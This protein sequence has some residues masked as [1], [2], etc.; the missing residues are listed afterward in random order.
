MTN[1]L[2][3]AEYLT[4]ILE[5]KFKLFGVSIGL[6]P[7]IGLLFG[8]GDIFTLLVGLYYIWVAKIHKIPDAAIARMIGNI[9][10]DFFIGLIPF[11]GDLF[12]FS[13]KAHSRNFEILKS[14]IE[15]DNTK[16]T[17]DSVGTT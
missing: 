15:S 16:E 6:D 11:I 10:I 17:L 8:A 1:H 9:A 14:Y 2:K 3:I 5:N 12:D 4:D 13:F 7:I